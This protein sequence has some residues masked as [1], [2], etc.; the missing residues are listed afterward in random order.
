MNRIFERYAG[1]GAVLEI[2]AREEDVSRFD[3]GRILGMDDDFVLLHTFDQEG[4]DDGYSLR[5]MD[6]VGCVQEGTLYLNKLCRM[7]ERFEP[8]RDCNAVESD[9]LMTWL[10]AYAQNN[11]KIIGMELADS[12]ELDICGLVAEVG[13]DI[14]SVKQLDTYGADDGIS[15]VRR[16]L[17]TRM[18]CDGIELRSRLFLAGK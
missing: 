14:I 17:I 10:A 7:M 12:G 16:D 15:H 2:Y 4:R 1:T 11:G 18:D 5:L 3:V 8:E 13:E 9:D 6:H